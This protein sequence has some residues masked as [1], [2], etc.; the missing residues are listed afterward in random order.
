MNIHEFTQLTGFTPTEKYYHEV[1]EKSYNASKLDK[2]EWC[3]EW[4]KNGGIQEAY[5]N[6]E[7]ELRVQKEFAEDIE[8]E[9]DKLAE[10]I[11]TLEQELLDL[12]HKHEEQWDEMTK[13][14]DD[15]KRIKE[16]F[17]L[18]KFKVSKF[19]ISR[20]VSLLS[21]FLTFKTYEN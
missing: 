13:A 9:R 20:G 16:E 14:Q 2:A 11:M 10:R 15:A 21:D 3:K 1:I 8:A 12:T 7:L 17:D 5:K 18:F 4:K 19:F 6:L